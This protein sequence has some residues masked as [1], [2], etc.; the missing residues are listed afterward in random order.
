MK[1]KIILGL[2]ATAA[3]ATPVVA[4]ISCGSQSIDKQNTQTSTEYVGGKTAQEL[5]LDKAKAES[6]AAAKAAEAAKVEQDRIAAEQAKAAEAARLAQEAADK[7]AQELAKAEQDKLAEQAR[8]AEADRLEAE[9]LAA[10]KAAEQTKAA[11]AAKTQEEAGLNAIKE[12]FA[13]VLAPY[14]VDTYQAAYAQ[15][16]SPILNQDNSIHAE[17]YTSR[18]SAT[19]FEA[20][21]ENTMRPAFAGSIQGFGNSYPMMLSSKFNVIKSFVPA[22]DSNMG[23]A[24]F[25][26]SINLN[27]GPFGKN[28]AE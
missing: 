3:I 27:K 2:T 18:T 19:T 12:S 21:L 20:A 6:E 14:T 9:R 25:H 5:Q 16:I 7:V 13:N 11:E 4:V 26:A 8:K 17:G 1:K 23:G 28:G 15:T 10:E 24:N 22:T